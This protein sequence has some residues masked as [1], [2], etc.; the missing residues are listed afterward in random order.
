[1]VAEDRTG[2]LNPIHQS[3]QALHGRHLAIVNATTW[4]ASS[5]WGV[6]CIGPNA[7][8]NDDEGGCK[9]EDKK[10][11]EDNDEESYFAFLFNN[12]I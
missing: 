8:N 7:W 1:M 2:P 10:V 12:I 3:N 11:E 9:R 6:T 5:N 4:L